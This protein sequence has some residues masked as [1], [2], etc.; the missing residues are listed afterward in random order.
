MR[1]LGLK[2][3]RWLLV[4]GL[5]LLAVGLAR[6][7]L[8]PLIEFLRDPDYS[9]RL[10]ARIAAI[11]AA[12]EPVTLE[13]LA[14]RC[15]NPGQAEDL[16]P[17]V[18]KLRQ[19]H[20]SRQDSEL[21]E[22]LTECDRYALPD[23]WE[24]LP[25]EF[26]DSLRRFLTRHAELVPVVRRVASAQVGRCP[27]DFADPWGPWLW[28]GLGSTGEDML[29]AQALAQ[30]ESGQADAAAQTICVLLRLPRACEPQLLADW[31][32]R[33]GAVGAAFSAIERWVNH[34]QPSPSP[35]RRVEAA[36][37][38][39]RERCRLAEQL[40]NERCL[41]LCGSWDGHWSRVR[42]NV[43]D[44]VRPPDG[45]VAQALRSIRVPS[46][47]LRAERVYYVDAVN[48]I[49]AAL[50]GPFPEC[51]TR[52]ERTIDH[53]LSR[54]PGR[55]VL[56]QWALD[57]IKTTIKFVRSDTAKLDTARLALA[58]LRYRARHRRL[59]EALDDL[60][61]GFVEC[62]PPDPY[63]GEPLR[64][65]TEEDG[66]VLYSIGRNGRD[67][68]GRVEYDRERYGRRDV[69]IRARFRKQPLKQPDSGPPPK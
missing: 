37:R 27:S 3:P 69:G 47:P 23:P 1:R 65:R 38:S 54:I 41:F 35:L 51:L 56:C 60:V 21:L 7:L 5:V 52:A 11:R 46:A 55:C 12:G 25:A 62:V 31:L 33:T 58:T 48:T 42:Y 34:T 49:L 8:P 59:P 64:Y 14:A 24:P 32:P 45:R 53:C 28:P 66:F 22:S 40:V 61:P 15:P 20:W 43:A 9:R 30:I 67:D 16:A 57:C 4:V 36:L 44:V 18:A 6:W 26:L 63:D 19:H 29:S 2:R 50:R 13:D 68:G 39:E 10:A 17:I